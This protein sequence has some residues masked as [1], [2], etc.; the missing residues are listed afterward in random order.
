MGEVT[1]DE[2]ISMLNEMP[3][4]QMSCAMLPLLEGG[5]KG[6]FLRRNNISGCSDQKHLLRLLRE[7]TLPKYHLQQQ[8]F[9]VF[10]TFQS[11]SL[12]YH[13]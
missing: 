6:E 3:T 12:E 7:D 10:I 2:E 9:S 13:S 8:L 1:H 4:E 5:D 11:T